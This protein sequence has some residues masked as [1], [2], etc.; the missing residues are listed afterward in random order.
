M[1]TVNFTELTEQLC[2]FQLTVEVQTVAGGVLRDEVQLFGTVGSQFFCF[3]DDF[4][5]RTT[6]E[7]AANQR[8]GTEGAAV[9]A[10]FC[11]FQINGIV[12]CGQH[13][14]AAQSKLLFFAV[15]CHFFA[16]QRAA[17]SV[18]DVEVAADAQHNVSFRDLAHQFVAVALCQTA[19]DNDHFHLTAAF[20]FA[21]FQNAFDGFSFGVFNEA[22]GVDDDHV[23]LRRIGADL[24][25]IMDDQRQQTLGI[26]L[27]LGTAQ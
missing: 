9:V 15:F 20:H 25:A 1:E 18:R 22:A 26:H 8:N 14:V 13:A 27:V 19:G 4:L 7:A 16:V 11:D 5:H 21:E 10:A 24:K 23:A 6:A 12:W 2:Q 3:L 17:D